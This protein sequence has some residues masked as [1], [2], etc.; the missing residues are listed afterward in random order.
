MRYLAASTALVIVACAS[1]C[2]GSDSSPTGPTGGGGGGSSGT[3]I[4][5]VGDRGASSFAP[6]P[7]TVAQGGAFSWRNNDTVTHRIVMND[8]SLDTGDIAP[9]ASSRALT[10]MTNGG[11]YHCAIHPGMV[12][13]INSSSGM[14]PPCS[15]VY[16]DS[17]R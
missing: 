12:G 8:G 14:P 15:G 11:N 6:N 17:S 5:I 13:S 4:A 1:A 3:A 2:G 7:S 10:L 16:C 9:G